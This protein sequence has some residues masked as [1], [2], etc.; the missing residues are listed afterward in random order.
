MMD[1]VLTWAVRTGFTEAFLSMSEPFRPAEPTSAALVVC[2]PPRRAQVSA[3]ADAAGLTPVEVADPY[4]AM[5]E[6]SRSPGD[7]SAII[8]SLQGTYREELQII[9]A[10]RRRFPEL[11]VWLTDIDGRSAMF[12]EAIRLGAD[13]LVGE[14]GLHRMSER[15][16]GPTAIVDPVSSPAARVVETNI[17]GHVATESAASEGEPV[18]E[19]IRPV[20]RETSRRPAPEPAAV[21][22]ASAAAEPAAVADAAEDE[23]P[24]AFSPGE[25]IL[26]AEELRAL[27]HDQP[28]VPGA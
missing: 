15:S 20:S 28:D 21:V 8:L 17:N 22:A 24:Y 3:W 27:L 4:A 26:T 2:S 7:V 16:P 23:D 6:L 11:D 13:G 9:A 19:R 14:D 25:P 10:I 12:A 5:A 18:A 1:V